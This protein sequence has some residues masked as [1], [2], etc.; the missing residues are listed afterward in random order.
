MLQINFLAK[1]GVESNTSA[2]EANPKTQYSQREM[3]EDVISKPAVS[4]SV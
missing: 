3:Q 1:V 4:K 2:D